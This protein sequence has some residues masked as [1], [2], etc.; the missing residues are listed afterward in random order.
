MARKCHWTTKGIIT[1]KKK[2]FT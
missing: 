2:C 1:H